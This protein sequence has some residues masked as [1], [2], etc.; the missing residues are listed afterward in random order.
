MLSRELIRA[1]A[2][3]HPYVP[4]AFSRDSLDKVRKL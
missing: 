4:F 1:H 2:I 3:V